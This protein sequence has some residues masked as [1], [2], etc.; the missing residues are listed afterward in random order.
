MIMRI[1]LELGF[2]KLDLFY[3]VKLCVVWVII[4]NKYGVLKVTFLLDNERNS[5]VDLF[6][7]DTLELQFKIVDPCY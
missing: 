1:E 5:Q 6:S 7:A 3:F 2:R 4:F